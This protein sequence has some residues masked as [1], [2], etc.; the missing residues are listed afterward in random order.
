MEG[1]WFVK[2]FVLCKWMILFVLEE[3]GKYRK[4]SS[5]VTEL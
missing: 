3:P 4:E 5:F 1:L 2:I